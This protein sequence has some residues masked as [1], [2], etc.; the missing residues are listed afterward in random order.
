MR[1]LFIVKLFFV[2]GLLGMTVVM[3][4]CKDK[5]ED[6][7]DEDYDNCRT[8]K[9][10]SAEA[11]IFITIN[12][13]NTLVTVKLYE[14]NFESG[15]LVWEKQYRNEGAIEFLDTD[16]NYS[17]TATYHSGNDTIVAV[18]G[19]STMV[20]SY[21]MCELQCYEIEKLNIDLRIE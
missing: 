12:N 10:N 8:N 19:G 6:C 13:E 16:K 18:D 20:T 15:V 14:G 5:Y 11:E 17:F 3:S 21:Q 2:L 4:S 7:T 9:P 1:N